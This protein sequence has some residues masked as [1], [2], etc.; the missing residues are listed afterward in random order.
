[1]RF[2]D[3]SARRSQI[4]AQVC[5]LATALLCLLALVG[6]LTGQEALTQ[7]RSAFPPLPPNLA[8]SLLVLACALVVLPAYGQRGE[9]AAVIGALFVIFVVIA[10][11]IEYLTGLPLAL[12]H[13]IFRVFGARLGLAPVAPL[14]LFPTVAFVC[15]SMGLLCLSA[16]PQARLLDAIGAVLGVVAVVIGLAFLLGY[17]YGKPLGYGR[18]SAPFSM[19][20][21]ASF[22]L[23]GTATR[24]LL[25]FETLEKAMPKLL[26]GI[27][28][29]LH[30]PYGAFWIF[31][32]A[33]QNLRCMATWSEQ[34]PPG[35]PA[36]PLSVRLQ[37]FGTAALGKTLMPGDGLPG[38]ACTLGRP[39]WVSD[40]LR[41]DHEA[42]PMTSTAW[43]LGLRAAFAVPVMDGVRC[44]GVLECFHPRTKAHD[45]MLL[46]A[47][48]AVAGQVAMFI[49]R[50]R[51][52]ASLR[53]SEERT[54]LIIETANDA[55]AELD[56]DSRITRWNAEAEHIFGWNRDEIVGKS[57]ELIIPA[58]Q[59]HVCAESMEQYLKTGEWRL[60]HRRV[61]LS[62]LHRDGHT[63]P[64]ELTAWPIH[65]GGHCRF[66]AF[67]SDI[68]AR[69]E[70]ERQIAAR[71]NELQRDLNFAREFQ[72]ALLPRDY[73]RVPSGA[74]GL[75]S[76]LRLNF[77]HVYK[78]TL[79]VGGDFFDVIAL[80]DHSAGVFIADVMGHGARS[81]L[82]TAILRTLLQDLADHAIEPA[83]FL[84]LLNNHFL[85]IIHRSTDLLFVSAFYL[86]LDTEAATA[87]YASA[88]HPSPLVAQRSSGQVA[89]LFKRLKGNPALGVRR[90]SV[91]QDFQRPLQADDLYFLFTDGIVEAS[92]RDGEEFGYDQFEKVISGNIHRD[93]PGL[94]QAVIDGVYRFIAGTP[95]MDD[96]CLVG[97]EAAAQKPM[98][99]SKGEVPPG[100]VERTVL[101]V[102]GTAAKS[103]Q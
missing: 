47:L 58:A 66:N 87:S 56:A 31:E 54:R 62:G 93:L 28:L 27:C 15:V 78:P 21:A 40:L 10:R 17:V 44:L 41:V 38:Q 94:N 20:A 63:F 99:S 68:T 55:F 22:A 29:S 76:K 39:V 30:W 85:D 36:E 79:T 70:A 92:N 83:R 86:V 9:R 61:E 80:S 50:R 26:R 51:T 100:P 89:P 98:T 11:I 4:A 53:E 42:N 46:A 74:N 35:V 52:E 5:G 75:A 7:L 101:D 69:K 19:S 102:A 13:W 91:Y 49:K 18:Q 12:D 96:I 60:Q 43:K 45:G 33:T 77:H 24:V 2:H 3:P 32:A 37:E 97:V 82:V 48:T 14:T 6:W 65:I 84:A 72:E 90:N 25:K 71:T 95:L 67:I 1:M 57:A 64:I 8:G 73:P 59:W 34:T 16:R 103:G 81:A 23:L 88:G